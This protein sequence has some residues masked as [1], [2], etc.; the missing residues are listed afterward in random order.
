[1]P[2]PL[3]YQ[4]SQAVIKY[5]NPNKRFQV[6]QCCPGF[7]RVDKIVP[8]RLECL[9][10]NDDKTTINNCIYRVWEPQQGYMP[11]K[12]SNSIR[13]NPYIM[14]DTIDNI[15]DTL[16][17]CDVRK[18]NPI[19]NEHVQLYSR[20]R[21]LDVKKLLGL[22]F[23]GRKEV[24]IKWL[25]LRFC[26]SMVPLPPGLKLNV[27][28]INIGSIDP[29]NLDYFVLA[30]PVKAV[31]ISNLK[32]PHRTIL[33]SKKLVIS[34]LRDVIEGTVVAR[35]LF[36]IK[37]VHIDQ[38]SGGELLQFIQIII[39][40]WKSREQVPGT[41]LSAISYSDVPAIL[42]I[43]EEEF[44][45][46]SLSDQYIKVPLRHSTSVHI[47]FVKFDGGFWLEMKTF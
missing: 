2:R 26:S 25:D 7:H 16:S 42:K 43:I 22:M 28:E 9:R 20:D 23:G 14:F 12:Y 6:S 39:R 4:S 1:M 40:E 33:K 5:M 35:L 8:L 18:T 13:F 41:R 10:L 3:T 29:K 27:E 17:G 38:I 19:Y 37:S 11:S 21:N 47:S 45:G 46:K 15:D 32:F 30:E 44:H 36:Y 31:H 24:H 34:H